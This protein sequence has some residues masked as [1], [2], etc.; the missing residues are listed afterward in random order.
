MEYNP[1]F[2]CWNVRGLNNPAKR[3][4]VREFVIT[5]KVNLA[6]FQETKMDVMDQYIVM[7][8]LGPSLDGFAYLPAVEM[9][10]GI[11][12]GWD[13]TRLSVDC[14]QLDPNFLTGKV[15]QMMAMNGGSQWSIRRKVMS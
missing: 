13:T 4:A 14:I 8:C 11:L 9:R 12:L 5:V 15:H 6:C 2:L 10:G 7:Q 3:K 1:E